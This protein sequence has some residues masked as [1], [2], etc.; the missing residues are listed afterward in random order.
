MFLL[1]GNKK[2]C[3]ILQSAIHHTDSTLYVCVTLEGY[4]N[5]S[6]AANMLY[7]LT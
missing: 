2:F 6:L 7:S 3:G 1:K 4:T 5:V